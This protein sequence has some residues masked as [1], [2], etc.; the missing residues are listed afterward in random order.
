MVGYTVWLII[1]SASAVAMRMQQSRINFRLAKI[2]RKMGCGQQPR[3]QQGSLVVPMYDR[4]S[5]QAITFSAGA[6]W[7]PHFWSGLLVMAVL[8]SL[9]FVLVLRWLSL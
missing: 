5:E 6:Y 7:G 1:G 3:C 4:R 9:L 8:V 2:G